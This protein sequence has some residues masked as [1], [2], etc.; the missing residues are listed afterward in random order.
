MKRHKTLCAVLATAFAIEVMGGYVK[1]AETE[2][3]GTYA[4]TKPAEENASQTLPAPTEENASQTLPAPTEENASQTLPAPTEENASQ[5][6]PAPAELQNETQEITEEE[7]AAYYDESVFIGDSIMQGFR[8][9]CAKSESFVHGIN[10]LAVTSYSAGN[11]LRPVAGKNVH[12]MYKGKKYHVWDAV[13]LAGSK[14]AFILL[15]MNDLIVTGLADSRDAYK[16]VIDKIV[17]ASPGIEIHIISVTYTLK[18]GKLKGALCNPNI[19]MYNAMLQEMADE[20]GWEYI[21]LCT[22]ISDGAGNLK[23][24]YC[25]DGYVH[26]TRAAYTVWEKELMQYAEKQLSK[27]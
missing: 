11:T 16:E 4:E 19:D 13:S 6:P 25:S 22:P 20:N 15:G 17:E 3:T 23:R 12:P 27:E 10:F 26:L 9:Y 5:T 14:R 2:P 1:A 18:D 21:D 7:L 8:N 24:E